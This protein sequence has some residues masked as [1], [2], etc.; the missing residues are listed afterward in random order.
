MTYAVLTRCHTISCTYRAWTV[1][2]IGLSSMTFCD[3]CMISLSDCGATLAYDMT[4]GVRR[5]L[6]RKKRGE[7]RES[8]WKKSFIEHFLR[9]VQWKKREKSCQIAYMHNDK[10]PQ[11][12]RYLLRSIHQNS[13]SISSSRQWRIDLHA[14]KWTCFS[15][16]L[17]LLCNL[18]AHTLTWAKVKTYT[19]KMR[20]IRLRIHL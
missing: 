3:T 11:M 13:H 5:E 12:I 20:W 19:Q 10:I 7:E 17:S 8:V 4:C 16:P 2:L 9:I 1:Y 14:M 6:Q 15:L 18:R